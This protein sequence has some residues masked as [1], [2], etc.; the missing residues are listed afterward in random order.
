M[1]LIYVTNDDCVKYTNRTTLDIPHKL[2]VSSDEELD[3]N[4]ISLLNNIQCSGR[5]II[6]IKNE[7][8]A[9][10]HN[11]EK[12]LLQDDQISYTYIF[13]LSFVASI[14]AQLLFNSRTSS[15][16]SFKSFFGINL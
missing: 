4:T 11:Y 6:D 14:A 7:I 10:I 15:G 2:L 16:V 1:P 12:S 9:I 8:T 5:N 3:Q 13:V